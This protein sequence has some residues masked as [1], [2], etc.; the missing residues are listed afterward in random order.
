LQEIW[1]PYRVH[2]AGALAGLNHATKVAREE[3]T[4]MSRLSLVTICRQCV[5]AMAALSMI[6]VSMPADAQRY[7]HGGYHRPPPPRYYGRDRHRGGGSG[8]LIAGALL[9][10]V[11]G[12]VIANSTSNASQPPP[13]VVYRDPP[14]PPPPGVYYDDGY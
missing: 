5:F 7:R 8:N 14:P 1:L 2:R 13:A 4:L 10:V 9:G 3:V 6:A 11:A 12:A